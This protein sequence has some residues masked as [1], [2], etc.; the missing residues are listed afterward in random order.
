MFS[1]SF[2]EISAIRKRF[3][4]LSFVDSEAAFYSA[5]HELLFGSDLDD[6]SLHSMLVSFG[7]SD[8]FLPIVTLAIR[9]TNSL[10]RLA[11]V[12][13]DTLEDLECLIQHAW[14]SI[15]G[16]ADIIPLIRGSRPGSSLAD[17]LFGF[18]CIAFSSQN[19]RD[20]HQLGIVPTLEPLTADQS[21][22]AK[23]F[24]VDGQHAHMEEQ[25]YVVIP[26]DAPTLEELIMNVRSV[27]HIIQYN[28]R[29]CGL[30]INSGPEKTAVLVS[31]RL[32][33]TWPFW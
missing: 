3:A 10:L 5:L 15:E 1:Y 6:Q 19:C 25:V 31:T 8:D 12:P 7:V 32:S 24:Q 2:L 33:A 14:Y 26:L 29:M 28:S 22:Q 9:R 18:V 21:H 23:F 16:C 11:G 17:L 4:A 13:P 30:T 27:A 20:L